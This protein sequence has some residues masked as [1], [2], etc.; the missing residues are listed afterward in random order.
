MKKKVVLL[1]DSIRLIGY[2]TLLPKITEDF[3]EIWQP[4]ENSRFVQF[5]LREIFDHSAKID[6]ADIVCFNS[7]E[8]DVC[9][10]FGDG[11]FTEPDYY[12]SQLVRITKI[13]QKKGKTVVFSTTTPVRNDNQFNSNKDIKYFNELAVNALT[14]MGVIINDLYSVVMYDL[15]VNIHEDDKIHLTEQGIRLCAEATANLLRT[16]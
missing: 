5:V 8:W 6:E 9:N 16:L 14:P 7:G 3:L 12:V 1:G 4:D 13:L 11:T 10:I 15:E 2:G